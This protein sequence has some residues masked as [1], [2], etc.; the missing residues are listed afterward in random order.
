MKAKS[1]IKTIKDLIEKWETL[2]PW[3]L[4]EELMSIFK[5]NEGPGK[6]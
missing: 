1:K 3:R 6:P 5:K 2:I 4:Y